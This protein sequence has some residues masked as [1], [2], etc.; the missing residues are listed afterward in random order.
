MINFI[1][2]IS[3]VPSSPPPQVPALAQPASNGGDA[4]TPNAGPFATTVPIVGFIQV[5]RLQTREAQTLKEA[6]Q[7]LARIGVGVTTEG[8]D[9]FDALSKTLPCRWHKESII[10]L[11]DVLISPPYEIENC[12]ANSSSVASLVQVKKVLEGE[13]RRLASA[14][15]Q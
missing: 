5:E 3:V 7:Q 12:Q 10:V 4:E 8:Q 15:K 13:K 6:T 1:K 2:E 9:I 14:R 11:D